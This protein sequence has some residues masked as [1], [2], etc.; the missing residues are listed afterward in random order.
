M[1]FTVAQPP[2]R[3]LVSEGALVMMTCGV[4]KPT[5][6]RLLPL[7]FRLVPVLRVRLASVRE[8]APAP[9]GVTLMVLAPPEPAPP[10]RVSAP[11]VVADCAPK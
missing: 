7:K 4:P 1:P 9:S 8:L 6:P 10:V 2:M 3:P 5:W 11:T